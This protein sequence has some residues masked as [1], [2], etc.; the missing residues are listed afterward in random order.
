MLLAPSPFKHGT[1]Q[2]WPQFCADDD[3]FE[4]RHSYKGESDLNSR[5]LRTSK[6]SVC[7]CQVQQSTTVAS[8]WRQTGVGNHRAEPSQPESTSHR[9]ER[10]AA[11]VWTCCTYNFSVIFLL[12]TSLNNESHGLFPASHSAPTTHQRVL[13]A[14]IQWKVKSVLQA[15]ASDGYKTSIWKHRKN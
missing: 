2:R 15:T 7:S 3:T 5:Q 14:D 8:T 10:F 12:L 6:W 11:S 4:M 9:W 13:L 1:R